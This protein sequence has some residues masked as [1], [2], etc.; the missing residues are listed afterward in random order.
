MRLNVSL[1]VL[2]SLQLIAGLMMQLLVVALVGVG[3]I[4]DAWVAA[5]AVPAVLFAILSGVVHGVWQARLAANSSELAKWHRLQRAAHGQAW[6]LC[7]PAIVI[8]M[9]TA[10]S[11]ID[12]LFVGF[13][14]E[15]I[16]L[17]TTLSML[18]LATTIANLHCAI[19]VAAL[20]GRGKFIPCELVTLSAAV[21]AIIAVFWLLPMF[22]IE[23]AAWVTFAR[24]TVVAI[25]LFLM[26]GSPFPSVRMAIS[27]TKSWYAARP[28]LIGG[29]IYKSGPIVDRIFSSMAPAS[30]MT[31]F[32]L[33]QMGVSAVGSVLERAIVTPLVP[34]IARLAHDGQWIRL[35][36]IVRS[37]LM[38]GAI[39]PI[40]AGAIIVALYPIWITGAQAMLGLSVEQARE[41]WKI[42]LIFSLL[43]YPLTFGMTIVST[44]YSIGDTK[45]VA[46]V[47][48]LGFLLSILVK[49]LS[50]EAAGLSGLAA[51]V[52]AH[53][54]LNFIVMALLLRSKLHKIRFESEIIGGRNGD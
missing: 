40:L 30:G 3:P 12:L 38:R 36:A 23:A 31:V 21:A 52:T 33:A 53:Y 16:E 17:A 28:I 15:Q 18:L 8:L 47:G 27:E 35:T 4:T 11:W 44:L 50:F 34:Q 32:N 45:T 13:S 51:G 19:S 26:T 14:A 49:Y 25:V 42:C 41:S 9:T 46:Q 20:R 5:Q 22:G 24:A 39:I 1:G 10:N 6:M 48:T 54:A 2:A 7:I 29:G 37:T 43:L